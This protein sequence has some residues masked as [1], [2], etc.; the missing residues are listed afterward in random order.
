MGLVS[1]RGTFLRVDLLNIGGSPA[2][3]ITV[4][5]LLF[6][7]RSVPDMRTQG[8]SYKLVMPVCNTN[9]KKRFCEAWLVQEWNSLQTYVVESDSL[10]AFKALL[11][12]FPEDFL[13]EFVELE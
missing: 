6:F 10:A 5:T 1:L 7:C 9:I 4:P 2:G 11:E 3:G 13:F 12:Q 8:H